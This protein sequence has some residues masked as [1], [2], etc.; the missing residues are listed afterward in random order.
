M[1]SVEKVLVFLTFG[2]FICASYASESLPGEILKSWENERDITITKSA[3]K[4]IIE[5]SQTAIDRINS[6]ELLASAYR[7]TDLKVALSDYLDNQIYLDESPMLLSILVEEISP[8]GTVASFATRYPKVV[9][10]AE[11]EIDMIL[12]NLDEVF[13]ER[14]QKAATLL[15]NIGNNNIKVSDKSSS[16]NCDFN[17]EAKRGHTYKLHCP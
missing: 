17:I 2:F 10:N 9:L 5:E 13:F 12:I 15:L 3:R 6:D 1:T 14:P 7:D 16:I 8:G 11:F 4:S